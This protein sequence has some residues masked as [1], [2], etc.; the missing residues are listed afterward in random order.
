MGAP[1]PR[2]YHFHALP[3]WC[4]WRNTQTY[5]LRNRCLMASLVFIKQVQL[6]FWFLF[7]K[8]SFKQYLGSTIQE[9]ALFY[10]YFCL[11][12]VGNEK[13]LIY[14]P[15]FIDEKAVWRLWRV[16]IKE[17]G[18]SEKWEHS[19]THTHTHTHDLQLVW[20]SVTET[21]QGLERAPHGVPAV[22][23]R[24]RS[25]ALLTGLRIW[26]CHELQITSAARTLHCVAVA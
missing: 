2:I 3:R 8:A 26:R 22:A 1:Q 23:Q 15:S 7:I 16:V 13:F 5:P 17:Y 9:T 24:V 11:I 6:S 12:R 20:E 18:K 19:Q 21:W 4:C 10:P 25:L 14:S